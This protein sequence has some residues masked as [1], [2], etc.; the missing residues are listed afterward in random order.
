MRDR[1]ELRR[2]SRRMKLEPVEHE[3]LFEQRL[4]DAGCPLMSKSSW[5]S[6][7]LTLLSLT[8]FCAFELDG[9]QHGGE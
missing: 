7:S 4:I 2:F 5:A 1:Y 8:A 3:G 9:S 6:I